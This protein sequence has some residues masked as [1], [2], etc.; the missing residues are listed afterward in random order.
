MV[1]CKNYS[2]SNN[3]N[4]TTGET[5]LHSYLHSYLMCLF[6]FTIYFSVQV[7]YCSTKAIEKNTS[8]TSSNSWNLLNFAISKYLYMWLHRISQLTYWTHWKNKGSVFKFITSPLYFGVHCSVSLQL[9]LSHN[10][11][12][13]TISET[14]NACASLSV[15]PF[16]LLLFTLLSTCSGHKSS[17][18]SHRKHGEYTT[19][20]ERSL[21]QSMYST[22]LWNR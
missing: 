20:N 17:G 10:C 9:Q 5:D 8:R 4:L 12:T 16:C 21:S 2:N 22:G 13:I 3:K 11:C 14:A 19:A 1:L 18:N 7:H 15:H 6:N